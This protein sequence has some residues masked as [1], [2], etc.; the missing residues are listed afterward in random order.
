MG[1]WALTN[2]QQG[3]HTDRLTHAQN[4]TR[5]GEMY[6]IVRASDGAVRVNS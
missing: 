1:M 4:P 5:V 6:T 2:F 3:A